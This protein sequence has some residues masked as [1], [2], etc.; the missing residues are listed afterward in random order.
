MLNF[1]TIL[2]YMREPIS[3]SLIIPVYNRPVEVDE[4]LHSLTLQTDS[5]FE[6]IIVEDGSI[7]EC[8]TVVEKYSNQL[9][10]QYFK[11]EN[12]G[13][14]SS[15]NYGAERANGNYFIFLDSDCVIP[16]QYI[17]EVKNRLAQTPFLDCFGGPDNAQSDFSDMQKAINY[18]MTSFFTTGGIRGGSEKMDKFFP[19]SFNMGYSKAVFQHT[20]GFAPM[21][22]GEDIDMSLRI[23][24][25][26]FKIGLIKEAFVYHKRRT[27][28]RQFFKQ[29]YNSGIARINLLKR[30]PGSLKIVHTFPALFTI[31]IILFL[32]LGLIGETLFFIPILL[33]CLIIGCDA[34]IKNNSL[35]VGLMAIMASFCQ[36]FGYGLGFLDAT[37]N[38]LLLGKP[39]FASFTKNFYK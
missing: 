16:E 20:N 31:G 19:R 29:V 38:R 5:N 25:A 33:F 35:T 4:L 14:G 22:F 34:T 2:D 1:K 15:R 7:D 8:K 18:A 11:K 6:I 30:H 28:F 17:H 9:K 21:R 10:V 26:G 37:W 23:L 32:I 39:E 24:K 36:L 12:S 3:L 13:P 27:K